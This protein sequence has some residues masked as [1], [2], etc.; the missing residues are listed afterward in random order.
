MASFSLSA[1]GLIIA[2]L[3]SASNIFTDVARKK[4]VQRHPLIPATFWCQVSAAVIFGIALLFRFWSGE[5]ILVRDGGNLFGLAGLH[6]APV[7][8]Y[9]IYLLLDVLLVS[10]ANV[11]YFLALQVS[12]LSLC[13][14]FLAFT[15]IF[16][17]PT[18]FVMLG[19]LPP[20]VKLLGVAL[21]V[22]GSTLMHRRLF[23]LG[24][25]A[26][27]KAIVTERGSRYML[28]VAFIFSITNPLEKKL[29]LMTDVY[30]QAFAFGLGLCVFFFV[31]TLSRKENFA[32]GLRGNVL[33]TS[34]A[35]IMDGVSLLLQFASYHYI[36]V[37]IA[38]SIKR[39]GIVLA[40][41]FGW[42]FFRER[43][44]SD[45]VIASSVMLVGVLM[46]YLPVTTL[47]GLMMIAITVFS[48]AIALYLTRKSVPETSALRNNLKVTT[49]K[50]SRHD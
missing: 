40:V 34:A 21:V 42:L 11:L 44:I 5:H 13:V 49:S 20:A 48:A 31:L 4:A 17:I 36:D 2:G 43:G 33:W 7:P 23:A 16:L 1:A 47:Q 18:G 32:L 29:V 50:A 39:A 12:P 26:P 41:F 8:T 28:T 15:P 46:I 10:A 6:L 22:F 24:W 38:V 30:T 14:P 25:T 9:F 3:M 37:V 27:L 35:G 19:E 45:K